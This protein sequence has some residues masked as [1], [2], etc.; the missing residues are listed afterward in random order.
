MPAKKPDANRD[1]TDLAGLSAVVPVAPTGGAWVLIDGVLVKET[2]E[3][4]AGADGDV[5]EV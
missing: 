1:L 4:D 5:M 3:P 2:P